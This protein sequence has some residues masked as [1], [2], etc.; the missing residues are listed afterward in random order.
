MLGPCCTSTSPFS[1]LVL[2]QCCTATI[3]LYFPWCFF[4]CRLG[5]LEG[6]SLPPPVGFTGMGRRGAGAPGTCSALQWSVGW[7]VLL[8]PVSSISTGC[9][10][11]RTALDARSGR[12]VGLLMVD[13]GLTTPRTRIPPA[14]KHT[15]ATHTH[16][17]RSTPVRLCLPP[18]RCNT[19][20]CTE[21]WT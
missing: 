20:F 17:C 1:L 15:T 2:G 5:P 13:D 21:R 9:L 12:C 3:R 8:G 10:A 16:S 11:P 7:R 14:T 18:S 19:P 4:C 6:T